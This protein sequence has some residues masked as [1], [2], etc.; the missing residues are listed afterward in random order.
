MLKKKGG[1]ESK[2]T[3][4]ELLVSNGGSVVAVML[5]FVRPCVHQK[6]RVEVFANEAKQMMCVMSTTTV[7]NSMR[8]VY[9]IKWSYDLFSLYF[10]FFFACSHITKYSWRDLLLLDRWIVSSSSSSRHRIGCSC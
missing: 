8:F 3:T 1:S 6:L 9:D 4:K 2:H 10:S 7:P 5:L